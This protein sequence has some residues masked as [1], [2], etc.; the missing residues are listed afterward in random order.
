[1]NTTPIALALILACLVVPSGSPASPISYSAVGSVTDKEGNDLP[2]AG[3]MSIDNQLRNW[4]GDGPGQPTALH[5]DLGI[6]EYQYY[7]AGY[8]LQVGNYTFAGDSGMF[9]L[10]LDHYP[11]PADWG[12]GDLMWFLQ[13]S[14]AN[15]AWTGW[16]GEDFTFYNADLTKQQADQYG[17]LADTIDLLFLMYL[18]DDPI[19]PDG[20]PFNL[21]LVKDDDPAPAPEPST[22]LL[23]GAGLAGMAARR[24]FSARRRSGKT[25]SGSRSSLI[26]RR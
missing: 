26:A 9:Y 20:P 3:K 13:D 4:R 2:I 23:L 24:K 15:S 19:L 7:I 8:S 10:T 5:D 1:M 18:P 11:T 22:V 12:F 14:S 21:R 6:Y 25:D 17:S 16:I